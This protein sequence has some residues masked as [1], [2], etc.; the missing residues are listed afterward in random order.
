MDDDDL[1]CH[2]IIQRHLQDGAHLVQ[3]YFQAVGLMQKQGVLLKRVI[4]AVGR[5]FGA[6]SGILKFR[7]TIAT[8]TIFIL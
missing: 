3:E 7:G 5:R 1:R 4:K 2:G 6:K 8:I